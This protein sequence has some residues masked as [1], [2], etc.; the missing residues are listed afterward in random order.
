MMQQLCVTVLT[1]CA[2]SASAEALDKDSAALVA[3][4]V[5][6][7]P[8]QDYA[9]VS[10]L[11]QGIPGLERAPNGRLWVTWY[12]GG[13]GEGNENYVVLVTSADDGKTW[14]TP[15]VSC[16]AFKAMLMPV[17]VQLELVT[18]PPVQPRSARWRWISAVCAG[19]TS[20]S[21]M[22]TSASVRYAE[23]FEHTITPC[24]AKSGSTVLAALEGSAEKTTRAWAASGT[25]SQ[26]CISPAQAGIAWS[27]IQ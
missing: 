12:S 8:G 15:K 24:W 4:K 5:Q 18:I 1:L 27:R 17:L 3:P 25:L 22:G 19:L 7:Q 11:W 13:K 9:G 14:S 21:R 26:I 6:T 20:G 10:R 23:A 16:R 2:A